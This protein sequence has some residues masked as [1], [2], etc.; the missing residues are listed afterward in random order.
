MAIRRGHGRGR[1]AD[2]RVV[3]IVTRLGG[4]LIGAIALGGAAGTAVRAAIAQALPSRMDAFPWATLAVNISGSLVLGVV[5]AVSVERAAPQR[6]LRPLLGTGFCGGLTTFS[7]FA[8]E[9]DA[10]V[11][12][13]RFAV[14]VGYAALSLTAGL[15][16]VW[17][18]ARV[19]RLIAGR[20]V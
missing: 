7:T 19:A 3:L 9:T 13:G 4:G 10:L 14:A 15:I 5:I 6:Y 2:P 20:E 12:A 11:R 18:G 8:V 17:V 1:Q 16:S